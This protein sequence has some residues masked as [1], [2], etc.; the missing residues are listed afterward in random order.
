MK[1]IPFKN[2][3]LCTMFNEKEHDVVE[4]GIFFKKEELPLYKVVEVGKLDNGL[5]ININDVIVTNSEPTKMKV[6]GTQYFLINQDYISGIV[7]V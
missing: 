2:Y 7:L 6:D 5:D 3:V 1:A 4:R